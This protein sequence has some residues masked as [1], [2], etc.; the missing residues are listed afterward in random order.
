MLRQDQPRS[1]PTRLLRPVRQCRKVI[2]FPFVFH[3]S[4][5]YALLRVF[6]RFLSIVSVSPSLS[7]CLSLPLCSRS[8]VGDAAAT[9][10]ASMKGTKFHLPFQSSSLPLAFFFSRSLWLLYFPSLLSLILIPAS[11]IVE[12]RRR[13]DRDCLQRRRRGDEVVSKPFEFSPCM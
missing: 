1:P 6:L 12:T 9:A 8:S 13:I 10:A 7:V 2:N 3:F 11:F 4:S 5:C